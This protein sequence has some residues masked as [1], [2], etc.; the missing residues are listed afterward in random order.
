MTIDSDNLFNLGNTY[1]RVPQVRVSYRVPSG[2]GVFEVQV[3]AAT[4]FGVFDQGALAIQTNPGASESM[5]F[6]SNTPPVVQ[7]RVAYGWK[8]GGRQ[9][10]LA[11]GASGGRVEA[12]SASG[13]TSETTHLLVTGELLAPITPAVEV[14]VE[15]FYGKATGFNGGV[16][17][18]AVVTSAG[19]LQGIKSWGGFAQLAVRPSEAVSVH[20]VSGIDNPETRPGDTPIEIGR[21]WTA[22]ANVFWSAAAHLTAAAE[23]QYLRTDYERASAS[24]ENVRL[25]LALLVPF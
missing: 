18:T 14:M 17:Q 12:R 22:L 7:G 4:F 10:Q 15:G 8:V 13:A 19:T 2:S 6:A 21:N 16:G 9:A 24:A 5:D 23:L 1:E 25:T 20:A 3:G 11:L